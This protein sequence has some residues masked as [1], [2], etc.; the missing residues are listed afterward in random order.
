MTHPNEDIAAALRRAA[1]LLIER[2][3]S[4][5]H[6]VVARDLLTSLV[7]T[8]ENGDPLSV[9]DRTDRFVQQMS[10]HGGPG[11]ISDGDT[12]PSF[13][14]S[15]Y[16]GSIN[17]LAPPQAIYRRDGQTLRALVVLGTALE[18]RPGRAHGGAVAA[19]FDD[20]MGALQQIIGRN[21]YTYSLTTV[22]H[23]PF[24]T[25]IEV[26]IHVECTSVVQPRF[27]IEATASVED[28]LIA[29]STGVFVEVD[30]DR[31][32]RH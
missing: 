17:A 1:D 7:K 3:L 4:E 26:S 29:S 25:D 20:A 32:S 10:V 14:E 5:A 19:V 15:P 31:W 27:T 23:A 24:P 12:F 18:G 22:Y 8:L 16:S 21:G 9:A 2:D 13:I 30:I 11:E 6:R 28:R